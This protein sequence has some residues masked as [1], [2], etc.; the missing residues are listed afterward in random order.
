MDAGVSSAAA[1]SYHERVRA[2]LREFGIPEELITRRHLV[3]CEE[4]AELVLAQVGAGGRDYLLTPPTKAAWDAMRTAAALDGIPLAIVSAFRSL[5]RQC[6]I[7]RDKLAQGQSI[8]QVLT[9][10]AP[11]GYSEHHSG[12]AIDIGSSEAAALEEIFET[13]PSYRWLIRHAGR[14]GFSLSFPRGNQY[15]YIHE[16]WHWCYRAG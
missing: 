13:T 11:P 16:P 1:A 15:G 6:E 9:A 7:V 12:C 10:S 5:D 2:A 4:P 3:L 8:D 14:F